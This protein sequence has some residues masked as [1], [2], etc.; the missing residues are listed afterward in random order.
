[1]IFIIPNIYWYTIFKVSNNKYM[2]YL[3]V[4]VFANSKLF[5]ANLSQ[6]YINSAL[7][8]VQIQYNKDA[9]LIMN[10]NKVICG[11]NCVWCMKMYFRKKGS[12]IKYRR[13]W[14]C[15]V[16]TKFGYGHPFRMKSHIIYIRKFKKYIRFSNLLFLHLDYGDLQNFINKF[17][18]IQLLNVYT[19]RGMIYARSLHIKKQGKNSQYSK[20]KSKIF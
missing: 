18:K 17:K 3:F 6:V 15:I 8:L 9:K 19:K 7:C 11:L 13:Q 1:M 12:W 20:F 16:T 10:F 14:P 5:V 2:L 4:D